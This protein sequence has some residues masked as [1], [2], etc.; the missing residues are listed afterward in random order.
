MSCSKPL[1]PFVCD[2]LY[3]LNRNQLERFSIVCRPLKNFID[4]YL[5]SKPYR[6]FDALMIRGGLYALIH[7][8]LQWHPN[9]DDYS[10]QQFLA[11]EACN[12]AYN[13]HLFGVNHK[14][15]SFAEMLP[16]LGPTVRIKHM[17]VA[18]D[19]IYNQDHIKE[20]ESIAYLWRDHK[21]YTE[22]IT[23]E[24]FQL[25]LDSPT[26]LQCQ[27][28][29]MDNAHFSFKDYKVL[30]AVKV[31]EIC[32]HNEEDIDVWQQFLEQP[33]VKPVVA[34]CCLS[35]QDTEKLL[36]RFSKAFSSA[37]S[38][39]AFKIVLP[40]RGGPLTEFRN[41]NNTSHEILELKK[42]FPPEYQKDHY[43]RTEDDYYTL[44]RSSI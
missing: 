5:H 26:I 4:R 16:Y 19:S 35:R 39:N 32:Y 15:H 43:L 14:F 27:T 42:G 2:S 23:A 3:Y 30:Y 9:R 20:M 36:D 1:S 17:R 7:D 25:I 24:N 18:G 41:T 8:H 34:F 10:V 22:T 38:P 21:I 12:D 44:E 29:Y 40:K 6:V 33:G 11:G 37:V 28:L 13:I 31:I